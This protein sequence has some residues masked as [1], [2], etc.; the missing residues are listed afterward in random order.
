MAEK[1]DVQG[2][3]SMCRDILIKQMTRDN[4]VR[5]A[6]LGHLTNYAPLKNAA[7]KAMAEAGKGIKQLKD[8]EELK[9][10]PDLSFDIM[11]Y[12]MSSDSPALKRRRTDSDRPDHWDPYAPSSPDPYA[13]SSPTYY[14]S[15]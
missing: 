3:M 6:I 1:Y 12:L 9:M 13:P 5:A 10:Y 11:D 14:M 4:F 2:L 15:D 8:W 7:M